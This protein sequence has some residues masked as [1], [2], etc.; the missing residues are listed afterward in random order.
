MVPAYTTRSSRRYRYYTCLKAQKQGVK[1]CPGQIVAA[2]RVELAVAGKFYELIANEDWQDRPIA[3]PGSRADWDVLPRDQQHGLLEQA[4]DRILYDHRREQA[5]I[6]LRRSGTGKVRQEIVVRVR[7]KP[8]EHLSPPPARG[9]A[10]V[11]LR[12]NLLPRVSR[13]LALASRLESLIQNGNVKDYADMARL[14][15]VSRARITQIMNLRNLAPA[16][17][18][19]LLFLSAEEGKKINERTLRRIANE[20]DWG[21]QTTMFA[22]LRIS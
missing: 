10:P 14:G 12:K 6:Q 18:E 20:T 13:L 19:Q 3:F 2:E 7:K 9:Q 15:G 17:Q 16:I 11:K 5:A 4:V 22:G 1:A 8:W 21:R